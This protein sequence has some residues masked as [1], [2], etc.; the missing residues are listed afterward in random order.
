MIL[1][2]I[3]SSKFHPI[4]MKYFKEYCAEKTVSR[5]A[6]DDD[7]EKSTDMEWPFSG[8]E[9]VSASTCNMGNTNEAEKRIFF[10]RSEE[11]NEKPKNKVY[12]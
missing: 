4:E 12:D 10:L 6:N 8:D 9:K 3:T 1:T 5:A 7:K 2:K 11:G